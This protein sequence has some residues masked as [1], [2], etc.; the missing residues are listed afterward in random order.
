MIIA[1]CILFFLA[2][3]TFSLDYE[4]QDTFFLDLE[5]KLLNEYRICT[6]NT[7][8][9]NI[10]SLLRWKKNINLRMEIPE[11]QKILKEFIAHTGIV[12]DILP[13]QV[14]K[15]HT[16]RTA[17]LHSQEQSLQNTLLK[18][19]DA[20]IDSIRTHSELEK[21]PVSPFDFDSIP[22][23][24]TKRVFA[25]VYNR[26]FSYP[27]FDNRM[28]LYVEHFFLR[29]SPF[30]INFFFTRYVKYYKYEIEGYAFSGDSLNKVVRPQ[31]T[32]LKEILEQKI[33]P[34][35]HIYR[36][37]YFDI[38]S[39]PIT[40]YAKWERDTHTVIV[41][42]GIKNNRYFTKVTV[43]SKKIKKIKTVADQ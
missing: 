18:K 13:C 29:D 4:D 20:T 15:W 23:G 9:V 40:P 3:N 7:I 14:L 11:Y 30:L 37:G 39:G 19:T 6:G 27:L 28:C 22:F 32:L 1:A 24:L 5:K 42:I 43:T 12:K 10:G 31:A 8:P 41:G 2:V 38:K 35:D 26:K 25:T 34:P 33:G 21:N 36:I 16:D 17:Y